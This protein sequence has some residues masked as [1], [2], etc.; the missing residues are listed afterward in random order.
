MCRSSVPSRVVAIALGVFVFSQFLA[1][2]T[3]SAQQ[4]Y[5]CG[6]ICSCH[7]L[8][9]GSKHWEPL[10][11][12]PHDLAND[13]KCNRTHWVGYAELSYAACNL[14]PWTEYCPDCGRNYYDVQLCGFWCNRCIQMQHS[15]CTPT[16]QHEGCQDTYCWHGG[17]SHM[18]NNL[19]H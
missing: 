2:R 6:T 19:V 4:D 7:H 16:F 11:Y 18:G 8:V 1:F 15:V 12:P 17:C 3:C 14:A 9:P 5:L 10:V 13:V